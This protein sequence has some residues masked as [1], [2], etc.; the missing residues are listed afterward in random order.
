MENPTNNARELMESIL[1]NISN[2]Y[3]LDKNQLYK[4]LDNAPQL[5]N[6]M[7]MKKTTETNKCKARKQDGHRC[8]RNCKSPSPYFCG[9]HIKNQKYG[10][11]QDGPKENSTNNTEVDTDE[12]LYNDTKYLVDDNNIVYLQK[13]PNI[14]KYEIVGKRKVNGKICFLKEL[15]DNNILLGVSVQKKMDLKIMFEKQSTMTSVN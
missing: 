5:N 1:D 10:C 4:Y 8:T 11:F 15:I 13:N 7:F 2:D 14:E 9:K 12:I 3:N 6:I